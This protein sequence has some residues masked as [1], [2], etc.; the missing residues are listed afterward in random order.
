MFII[1]IGQVDDQAVHEIRLKGVDGTEAA[2]LSYGAILRDLL[3]PVGDGRRRVVLG[4]RS[5]E[6]YVRDDAYFGATV[7][8]CINRIKGG[9]TLDGRHYPLPINEGTAVHLHGGPGAFS[10][11]V[12]RHKAVDGRAEFDLLSPDGDNG[13]PGEVAAR[14]VYEIP[15]PGTLRITMSA[16][17]SAAT[18][19]NLGHHS[20]FSLQPGSDVRDHRMAVAADFYTPLH[21]D[22]IPTGE[23]RAV[24]GTPYDFRAERP[25]R[26]PID[27]GYDINF[28]LRQGWRRDADDEPDDLPVAARLVSPAGDLAME[29]STT[30]PGLQFYEGIRLPP[31][32]EDY[33]GEPHLPYRGLCLEP[34]RFP[35]AVNQPHFPPM[36]LRPGET[37][38]QVTQFRFFDPKI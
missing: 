9:F 12:W 38:H 16:T 11:R 5:L 7:G 18:V 36:V 20:Y 10:K 21:A 24:A 32:A 15:A 33:E 26:N 37:Y 35:D 17:T 28:V 14:C 19:V 34:Q 31:T 3:V 2:I 13:Y 8:R 29:L 30:E 4:F 25:I 27:G 23:I 1:Q 6:G 22:L